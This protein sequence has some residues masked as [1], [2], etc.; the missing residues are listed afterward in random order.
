MISANFGSHRA[1]VRGAHPQ[2]HVACSICWKKKM[3]SLE[4]GSGLTQRNLC[5]VYFS[6]LFSILELPG[7]ECSSHRPT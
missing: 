4:F 3:L 6:S 5:C 1:S 7:L 2:F